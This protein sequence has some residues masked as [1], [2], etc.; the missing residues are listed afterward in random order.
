MSENHVEEEDIQS[1]DLSQEERRKD[2]N[3]DMT[4]CCVPTSILIS[5][6]CVCFY[7]SALMDPSGN[8][9]GKHCIILA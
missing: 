1:V 2:G 3:I 5:L 6:V 7:A 4:P 9:S 8:D